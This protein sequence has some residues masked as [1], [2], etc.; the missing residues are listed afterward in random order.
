M[1]KAQHTPGP[2]ARKAAIA[3]INSTVNPALRHEATNC[4]A[5]NLAAIIERETAVSELLEALVLAER[6]LTATLSA[7]GYTPGECTDSW[8]PAVK[9]EVAALVPIRAAIAKAEGK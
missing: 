6:T 5:A 9:A 3:I 8:A 1:T 2:L 4:N 7:R